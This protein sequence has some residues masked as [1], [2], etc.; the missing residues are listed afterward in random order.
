MHSPCDMDSQSYDRLPGRSPSTCVVANPSVAS[1]ELTVKILPTGLGD[2]GDL[3]NAG[4]FS[5][6]VA[7]CVKRRSDCH[8]GVYLNF[9]RYSPYHIHYLSAVKFTE[10]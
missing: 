9:L 8:I 10:I 2:A 7:E 1:G 6:V 4:F 3:N 5:V